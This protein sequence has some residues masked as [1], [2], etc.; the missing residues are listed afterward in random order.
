MAEGPYDF[1][2]KHLEDSETHHRHFERAIDQYAAW[3]KHRASL[4][5][6]GRP[7]QT[8]YIKGYMQAIRDTEAR[9][10]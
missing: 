5:I 1:T 2:A 6:P 9:D 8:S 7:D 3:L 4:G 10:A